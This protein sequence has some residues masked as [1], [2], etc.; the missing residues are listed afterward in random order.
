MG[1]NCGCLRGV[2]E[3]DNDNVAI[4]YLHDF[5]S[6]FLAS[7]WPRLNYNNSLDLHNLK[8]TVVKI[9]LSSP[10]D[11]GGKRH[12]CPRQHLKRT[13]TWSNVVRT[14]ITNGVTTPA[15]LT[16]RRWIYDSGSELLFAI[17]FFG[18]SGGLCA[19]GERKAL[20]AGINLWRCCFASW[21]QLIPCARSVG[22]WPQRWGN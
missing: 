9:S 8:Q 16:S 5:S 15:L 13:P 1:C 11:K 6:R 17:A 3:S 7:H 14:K 12:T 18:R 10:F 4:F 19:S 2:T 21:E 22:G 20:A